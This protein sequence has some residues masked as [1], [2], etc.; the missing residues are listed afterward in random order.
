MSNNFSPQSQAENLLSPGKKLKTAREALGLSQEDVA[1]HLFLNKSIIQ[2][3]ECD[4]YEDIVARTY[5]RG[6]L[7]A[8]AQMLHLPEQEILESFDQLNKNFV[9]Y[10]TPIQPEL[11]ENSIAS[12]HKK[13]HGL[14]YVI[15]IIL[16]IVVGVWSFGHRSSLDGK[17]NN[18]L[19]HI[20]ETKSN[21]VDVS[22]SS[23]SGAANVALPPIDTSYKPESASSDLTKDSSKLE[24]S[25]SN[26]PA[27]ADQGATGNGN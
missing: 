3:L 16:V 25:D 27:A 12:D 15:V 7:R 6:Y 21:K 9:P 5:A 22:V 11:Y 17:N 2:A 10:G 4:D 19:P 8:Y 20:E 13:S 23:P 26:L 24:V 1:K 14:T 18:V